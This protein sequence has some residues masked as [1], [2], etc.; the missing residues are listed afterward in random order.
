MNVINYFINLIYGEINDHLWRFT[1]RRRQKTH[2]LNSYYATRHFRMV[3]RLISQI[4]C[5]KK[6]WYSSIIHLIIVGECPC[7]NILL[8]LLERLEHD[9][10]EVGIFLDELCRLATSET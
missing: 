1:V 3:I 10:V 9:R 7:L 5:F 4:R 8:V 6:E 2:S